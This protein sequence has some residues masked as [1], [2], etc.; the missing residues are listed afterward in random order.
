M[1]STP[2]VTQAEDPEPALGWSSLW[3]PAP[4]AHRQEAAETDLETC[5]RAQVPSSGKPPSLTCCPA[6]TQVTR[7]QVS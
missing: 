4:G 1:E 5:P 2:A 3:Q 6:Q 7:A